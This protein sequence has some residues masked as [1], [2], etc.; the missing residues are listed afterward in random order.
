MTAIA[1]R[2]AA[3]GTARAELILDFCLGS[4]EA[5]AMIQTTHLEQS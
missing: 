2:P 4:A 5:C 3:Q 1:K